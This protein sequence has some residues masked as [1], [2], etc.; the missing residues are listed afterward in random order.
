[1]EKKGVSLLTV[2]LLL[3]L[4]SFVIPYTLLRHVDAWYG[5]FLWWVLVTIV[6]IGINVVV[7]SAWRD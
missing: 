3:M 7:S 5:S 2:I 6:V 1:M 4:L